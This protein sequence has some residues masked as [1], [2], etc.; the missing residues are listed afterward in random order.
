MQLVNKNVSNLTVNVIKKLEILTI[1][2][3][4]NQKKTVI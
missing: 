2:L 4:M 1:H 3:F